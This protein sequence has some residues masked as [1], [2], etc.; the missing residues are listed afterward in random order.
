MQETNSRYYPVSPAINFYVP[1]AHSAEIRY[2]I[3]GNHGHGLMANELERISNSPAVLAHSLGKALVY[4]T[5]AVGSAIIASDIIS[6]SARNINSVSENEEGG[7][8]HLLYR[9]VHT[10]V[11]AG[12]IGGTLSGLFAGLAM[13][14]LVN[15][16]NIMGLHIRKERLWIGASTI[17]GLCIGSV[18]GGIYGSMMDNVANERL[19]NA[20]KTSG[21]F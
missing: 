19:P 21:G 6:T 11:F 7:T 18:A 15:A 2:P 3:G 9:S 16:C 8:P 10:G 20:I 12:A 14:N 1:E 13:H 4:A 17:A 5:V